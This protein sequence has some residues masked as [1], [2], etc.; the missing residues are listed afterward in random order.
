MG[1]G[2]LI[3]CYQRPRHA[4]RYP[5]SDGAVYQLE[6]TPTGA[7]THFLVSGPSLL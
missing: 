2:D 4:P 1:T 6:E 5:E 7:V 3:S